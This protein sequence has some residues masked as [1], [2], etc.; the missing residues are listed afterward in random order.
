M[1]ML[2]VLVVLVSSSA[3]AC[4][5]VTPLQTFPRD[6]AKNVPTNVVLRVPR[7]LDRE[8][9]GLHLQRSDGLRGVEI[10]SSEGPFGTTVIFPAQP[11]EPQ[12]EYAVVGGYLAFVTFTTGDGED[13]DPPSPV[14][15]KRSHYTYTPDAGES[16]GDE[17]LWELTLEGGDD[18][19]TP[20]DQLQLLIQD[21]KTR[22]IVGTTA[23]GN[24][25]VLRDS[26]G[27]NFEPP[28]GDAFE[29]KF[30][31]MDLAGNVSTP[32]P[33]RV[34]NGCSSSGVGP[35]LLALAAFLRRRDA[36]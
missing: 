3:L 28:A 20:R 7:W 12:T 21:T 17:R 1:K 11:L 26:C 15:L 36:R 19:T 9:A 34:V 35:L 27:A 32:G 10:S 13:L 30:Q 23:Y 5:C 16:C 33:P 8:G 14:T 4:H 31:V 22:D 18:A 6:G 2:V 25:L 24:E 29:L